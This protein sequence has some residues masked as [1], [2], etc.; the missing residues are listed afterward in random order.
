MLHVVGVRPAFKLPSGGGGGGAGAGG[1]GGGGGSAG[2]G[3]SGGG[4][5][6]GGASWEE[7][8]VLMRSMTGRE[9]S[10]LGGVP[11]RE[12]GD[13]EL[14]CLVEAEEEWC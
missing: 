9:P 6:G 10:Q 12:M 5:G 1:G 8:P 3:G 13:V 14:E 4:G 7:P 11:L 2:G